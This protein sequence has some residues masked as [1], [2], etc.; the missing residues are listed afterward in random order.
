MHAWNHIGP[1]E[2]LLTIA[3]VAG[4]ATWL[5]ANYLEIYLRWRK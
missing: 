4:W 3:W 5:L 1:L 2:I